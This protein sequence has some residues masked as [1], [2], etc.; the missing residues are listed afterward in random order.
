M[1]YDFDKIYERKETDCLK[2]DLIKPIF[3]YDDVIPMWVAD[4]DFPAAQPIVDALKR[5]AEHPIYGYTQPG[6]SVIESVVERLKRKFNWEIKPEWIVFTPGVVPALHVAVRSLTSLGDEVIMQE[7]AYHPFFPAVTNSG[8]QIATNN[9]KLINGRYEIDYEDLER[10]F[11]P[12]KGRL[13]VPSRVKTIL[14]C[15]PHNPVGRVWEREEIIRL[16][17]IALKNDVVVISDEI[18]C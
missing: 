14:F 7:P 9:L 13:K 6:S 15:N 1:Q 5:R 18:H 3:G 12:K 4:M 10:K 17:E 16:G 2:W 8:C 11:Q